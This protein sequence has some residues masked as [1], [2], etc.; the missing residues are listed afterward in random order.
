MDE[1]EVIEAELDLEL[2]DLSEAARED[3]ERLRPMMVDTWP[4]LRL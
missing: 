1:D 3:S 4:V 2:H